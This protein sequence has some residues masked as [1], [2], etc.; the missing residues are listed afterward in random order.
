MMFSS[1]F[2]IK[3]VACMALLATAMS[4]NVLI[5]EGEITVK[6]REPQQKKLAHK[7]GEACITSLV[8]FMVLAQQGKAGIEAVY[9]GL[10]GL[11]SQSSWV[12]LTAKGLLITLVKRGVGLGEIKAA[13][14]EMMLATS[15]AER[16]QGLK[17]FGLLLQHSQSLEAAVLEEAVTVA[18][19]AGESVDGVERDCALVLLYFCVEHGHGIAEA[20]TL[21]DKLASK[22]VQDKND[23]LKQ[24][25]LILLTSCVKRGHGYREAINLVRKTLED[26]IDLTLR[27]SALCL[28]T[29]L[30]QQGQFYEEAKALA[31][32]AIKSKNVLIRSFALC[33]LE[34]RVKRGVTDKEMEKT[35]KNIKRDIVDG[36]PTV[37]KLTAKDLRLLGALTGFSNKVDCF[38]CSLL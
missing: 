20:A 2:S 1:R 32:D 21:A 10:K 15:P 23:Y 25:V 36:E 27:V 19:K 13:A 16:S 38:V 9:E 11:R 18:I 35:I 17:L 12:Q 3:H 34:A 28:L 30:V 37:S 24:Q 6:A 26:E 14:L 7:N 5:A 22:A 4:A 29:E 33:V 8:S 31:L